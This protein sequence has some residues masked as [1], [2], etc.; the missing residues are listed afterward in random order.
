MR[1]PSDECDGAESLELDDLLTLLPLLDEDLSECWEVLW[2]PE[3]DETLPV[4][5]TFE[6]GFF[7]DSPEPA[8]LSVHVEYLLDR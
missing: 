4:D 7:D 8:L 5:G 3:E 2:P 6:I 1:T